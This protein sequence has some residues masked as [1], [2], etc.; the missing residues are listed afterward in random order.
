Q[1][2]IDNPVLGDTPVVI[3]YADYRDFNGV[4]FPGK[5]VRTQGGYPVLD[6]KV[7]SVTKN[8]AVAIEGPA[9]VR[10]SSPPPVTVT[11]EK[12]ADGV[13]YMKGGGHHSVAIDQRDHIVVV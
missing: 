3:T 7:S 2:W 4:L 1:T 11:A 13:F 8:G 10:S 12:L 9:E 5:I 6:I